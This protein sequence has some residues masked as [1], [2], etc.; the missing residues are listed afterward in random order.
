M[1]ASFTDLVGTAV[2]PSHCFDSDELT[3]LTPTLE[4]ATAVGRMGPQ[5]SEAV[6]SPLYMCPS[7]GSLSCSNWSDD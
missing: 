3:N 2:V 1:Q 4:T 5:A 6:A 7:T